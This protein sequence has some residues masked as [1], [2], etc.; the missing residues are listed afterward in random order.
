MS[1]LFIIILL[2]MLVDS[3][4]KIE[5]NLVLSEGA[6]IDPNNGNIECICDKSCEMINANDWNVRLL[7]FTSRE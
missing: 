2:F 4:F 3:V 5:N 6:T 7:T 1:L